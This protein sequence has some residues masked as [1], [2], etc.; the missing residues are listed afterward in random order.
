MPI[1]GPNFLVCVALAAAGIGCAKA[2]FDKT[3]GAPSPEKDG[4]VCS[5]PSETCTLGSDDP[6][7]A[8]GQKCSYVAATPGAVQTACLPQ[9]TAKAFEE[10]TSS[11]EGTNSQND[12]CE[13]GSICLRP[14]GSEEVKFCFP[15]CS[16]SVDC[17]GTACGVRP[18][19]AKGPDVGVCDPTYYQVGS[20]GA[21]DPFD[22]HSCGDLRYCFLVPGDGG[23]GKSRTVCD[24]SMG[25]GRDDPPAECKAARD[26]FFQFTCVDNTC[27]QVCKAKTTC[28]SGKTCIAMGGEY[29]YCP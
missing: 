20:S 25:D 12:N 26:C 24:Y 7:S 18:L 3:D 28:Y 2:E 16:T 8:C 9:G 21:C 5:A 17:Q 27:K 10:C 15:L 22:D 6:C 23:T 11:K 13:A 29:G 19:F 14:S 4:P 1:R